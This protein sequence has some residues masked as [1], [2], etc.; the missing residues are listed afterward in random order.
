[1]SSGEK[2]ARLVL[3]LDGAVLDFKLGARMLVK[4]RGITIVGGLAIAVAIAI[5]AAFFEFASQ[6]ANPT[7]A[8]EDGDR[9]VGIRTWD[10]VAAREDRRM[11]HDVIAWRT[12]LKSVQDLGGFR[13]I[14]QNLIIDDGAAEPVEVAVVTASTFQLAR[15]PPLLGRALVEADQQPGAV[16]VIVISYDLWLR[17]FSSD[18]QV[19]GRIPRRSARSLRS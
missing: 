16:P 18:P 12:Q 2:Q 9:I 13:T 10:T 6:V 8:L 19:V 5:G 1:M 4:Y 15:V 3:W 14:E 11:S 7:L 17:R